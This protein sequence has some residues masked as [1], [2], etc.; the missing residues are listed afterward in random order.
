MRA[1]LARKEERK[2]KTAVQLYIKDDPDYF[3]SWFML[4]VIEASRGNRIRAERFLIK[5]WKMVLPI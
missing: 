3:D 4:A 2:V 1:L 5:R